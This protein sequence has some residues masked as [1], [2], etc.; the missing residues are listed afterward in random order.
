MDFSGWHATKS[1][2]FT[3]PTKL[4]PWKI[5]EPVLRVIISQAEHLSFNGYDFGNTFPLVVLKMQNLKIFDISGSYLN[6]SCGLS[7]ETKE[8]MQKVTLTV[9][10]FC[11]D[12][13]GQPLEIYL[14]VVNNYDRCNDTRERLKNFASPACEDYC[15][16]L[17]HHRPWWNYFLVG[18]SFV[19]VSIS[20][21]LYHIYMRR[22]V[23]I[24][25][26]QR[27]A[28]LV[29]HRAE[30][31]ELMESGPITRSLFSGDV[32]SYDKL[33]KILDNPK[34][35]DA[36]K[37]LKL[38]I[39]LESH[40]GNNDVWFAFLHGLIQTNQRELAQRLASESRSI[41]PN[42]DPAE[43]EVINQD[44]S[45]NEGENGRDPVDPDVV[46]ETE[47][48]IQRRAS[49]GSTNT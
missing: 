46:S 24:K 16:I 21:S 30:L 35:T 29:E 32:I 33:Q 4:S 23:I 43:R 41:L 38:L 2:K 31:L 5:C 8:F 13:I 39:W 11:Y 45:H 18:L 26:N 17:P 42:D 34:C 47:P 49:Y 10:G 28:V 27:K 1:F 44:N 12:E 6:C 25:R 19:A 22:P 20:L 9:T 7:R 37:R 36:D 15:D 3:A 14:W 48:I 40:C